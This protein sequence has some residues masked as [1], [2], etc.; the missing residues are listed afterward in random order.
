MATAAANASL[1]SASASSIKALRSEPSGLRLSS[2]LTTSAPS[3]RVLFAP[4]KAA[5]K[6]K[7]GALGSQC[8][9][10][11]SPTNIIFVVSTTLSLVS[12]RFGLAPSST[13]FATASMKLVERDSGMQSGDPAG[14]TAA[15][16]LAFG[17]LGHIIAAGITLG[18]AGP[19]PAM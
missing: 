9:Y 10:L 1:L 17:A 18:L 6:G 15:D 3:S 4:K 7:N 12:G 19:P 13:R 14:F 2:P 5:K 8:G 16:V 11:G